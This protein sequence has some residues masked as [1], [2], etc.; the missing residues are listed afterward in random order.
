MNKVNSQK[1]YIQGCV[2]ARLYCNQGNC[3]ATSLI[4]KTGDLF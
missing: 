1:V 2:F 3:F 4:L